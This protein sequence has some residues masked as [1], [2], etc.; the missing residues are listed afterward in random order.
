MIN[1]NITERRIESVTI[2]DLKGNIRI[3]EGNVEFH[4]ALRA[5]VEKGERK[6]L[7]NLA[8]VA[9]MDS[10]GLGELVAGFTKLQKI[11]GSL[12]LL[13][14]TKRV[15]ELMMITK[16]LTVF[17][18]YENEAEAVKSFDNSSVK[19]VYATSLQ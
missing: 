12:K 8:D 4:E 19:A 15:N 5:L 1:L 11:G 18:V 10:S 9:Y 16:L 7:I 13:H 6:I 2:L 14:L 3:G 17:D